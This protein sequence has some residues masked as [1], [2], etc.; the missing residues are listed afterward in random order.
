MPTLARRCGVIAD[1]QP[2][3]VDVAVDR[4]EDPRLRPDCSGRAPAPVRRRRAAAWAITAAAA[5]LAAPIARDLRSRFRPAGP[6]PSRR[7]AE[8]ARRSA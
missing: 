1:P 5:S 4:G 8:S 6:S 3:I 7:S 2:Q